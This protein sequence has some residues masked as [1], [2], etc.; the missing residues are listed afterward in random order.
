MIVSGGV[1]IY[2]AEAEQVLARH[3]KVADVAVIGVPDPD[4]GE[5]VKALVVARDRHDPPEPDE[6]IALCREHLAA[7]KCPRSIDI[8]STVGRNAMGKVNKR[9]LRAPY[10]VSPWSTRPAGTSQPQ[11]SVAKRWRHNT[12]TPRS[13]VTTVP[14][15]SAGMRTTWWSKRA[16]LGSSTSTRVRFTQSLV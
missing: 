4:M 1:N 6:L 16:P 10:W 2:P 11:V 12:R 9:A 5:R 8:V 7:Y 3:P 13:S 14:A 15:A